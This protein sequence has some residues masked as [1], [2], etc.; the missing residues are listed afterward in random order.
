M[1]T[2]LI[3]LMLVACGDDGTS[4]PPDVAV[5]ATSGEQPSAGCGMTTGLPLGT[6]SVKSMMFGG[7]ERT[8]RVRLPAGYDGTPRPIVFVLHGGFGTAEQIQTRQAA[9]DPI[10][11]REGVIV[12]YP[13]GIAA[14]ESATNPLVRAQTWNGGAC[15]GPAVTQNVDDV[16]FLTAVLDRVEAEA[17]V[18]K[19]RVFFTGM[20]N[21]GIMSYRMACERAD[22]VT[23]I[24]PVAGSLQLA[25]CTP[26]RKVP[27]FAV[28]GTLDENVPYNGGMGCGAG[29]VMTRAIP[30]IIAEWAGRNSC[31]G[32]PSTV[33]AEGDGTCVSSGECD[34]ETVL[35][36][37]DMGDHSWP[38]GDSNADVGCG[39]M[40]GRQSTTFRASE[41]IWAFFARQ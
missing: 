22:R 19:A 16:G 9:F 30:D 25:P 15:C 20:S 17:C 13:N 10:A 8:W 1:R 12:V 29:M 41:A 40:G 23:A 33:F 32:S 18:D 5:D 35:C 7:R 24:A 3:G 11:E 2:A 4:A 21:G 14:N 34:V 27:I 28:H 37:I 31:T 36:S 6:T 38:A 26:S 39:T